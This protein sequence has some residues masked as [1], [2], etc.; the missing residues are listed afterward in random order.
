MKKVCVVVLSVFI[1]LST[2]S[3]VYGGVHFNFGLIPAGIVIAPDIDGFKAYKS[4]GWSY[5]SETISG[6]VLY[7]P[8]GFIGLDFDSTKSGLGIDVFGNYMWSNAITGYI[9]GANVSYIFPHPEDSKFIMRVKGGYI[10]GSLDWEGDYTKVVFDDADGWQA[11][12]AFDV[13]KKV[14]F[15]SELL[16]RSLEFDVNLAESDSVNRSLLDLSGA[17][18]N[19][20]IKFSF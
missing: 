7:S 2:T 1:C 11:G 18:I 19:L 17:V 8:G 4:S 15:Y 13:G 3:Y 10:N 16:Y 6:S 5:R 20:G 9:K 14:L 12:I